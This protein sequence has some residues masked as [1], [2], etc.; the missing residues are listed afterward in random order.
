MKMYP[1]KKVVQK[2]FED[3][4]KK[5]FKTDYPY[6]EN[7]GSLSITKKTNRPRLYT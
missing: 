4:F 7:G 6:P 3:D 2:Q 5:L 1:N